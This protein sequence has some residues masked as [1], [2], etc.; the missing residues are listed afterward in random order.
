MVSKKQKRIAIIVAVIGLALGSAHWACA[1]D[2]WQGWTGE[3]LAGYSQTSGNTDNAAG[4]INAQA[5]REINA[6]RLKLKGSLS[7]AETDNKMDTQKWDALARYAFDFGRGNRWFGYYQMLVDHD[8]FA[9]IDYR[10]TPGAGAGYHLIQEE[11]LVWD[12]DAGLGYRITRYRKNTAADD[13]TLT[14]QLHTFV[15]KNIFE[16]SSVSEDLTVSPGLESGAGVLLHSESV[17]TNPINDKFDLKLKYIVDYD[18]EPAEDATKTD[19][20]FVAGLSYK[21]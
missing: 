9:D 18:S 15:E 21:F 7:Y 16:K 8:Y 6:A 5:V 13:E 20:Q 2:F 17:F 19:T 1:E 14:A 4:H 12:A 3:V 10:I 11:D